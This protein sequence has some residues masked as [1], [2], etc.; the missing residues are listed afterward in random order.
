MWSHCFVEGRDDKGLYLFCVTS[1][2]LLMGS[3]KCLGDPGVKEQCARWVAHIRGGHMCELLRLN[4]GSRSERRSFSGDPT[5][6]GGCWSPLLGASGTVITTLVHRLQ[7]GVEPNY[8]I[9]HVEL[10]RYFGGL[11]CNNTF[12]F[13]GY[14]IMCAH[15]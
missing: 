4:R 5:L 1:V 12:V 2:R 13:S 14:R 6:Q 9:G 8:S 7:A 15:W 11:L 10:L 3:G